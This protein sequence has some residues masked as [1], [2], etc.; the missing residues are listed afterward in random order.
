MCENKKQFRKI[1]VEKINLEKMNVDEINVDKL[2][3][4]QQSIS[5]DIDKTLSEISR[6]LERKKKIKL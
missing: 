1:D 5:S 2:K 4:Q 3:M 6:D